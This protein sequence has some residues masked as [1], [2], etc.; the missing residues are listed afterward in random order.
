M[1][2]QIQKD[3]TTAENSDVLPQQDA[4]PTKADCLKRARD[5]YQEQVKDPVSAERKPKYTT[6]GM[7]PAQYKPDP[8]PKPKRN[9]RL[10]VVRQP[11]EGI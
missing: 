4:L 10:S 6:R 3:G 7:H 8:S 5:K 2:H 9:Q 11:D 1:R